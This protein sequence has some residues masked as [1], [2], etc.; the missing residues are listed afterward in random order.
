MEKIKYE[1]YWATEY[2]WVCYDCGYK[3][4]GNSKCKKISFNRER[5]RCL[6][7]CSENTIKSKRLTQLRISDELMV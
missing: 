4:T 2:E 1:S 5:T 3:V 6:E 7:C